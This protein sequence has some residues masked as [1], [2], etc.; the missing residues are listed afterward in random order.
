MKVFY[1]DL[2]ELELKNIRKPELKKLQSQIGYSLVDYVAKNFYGID[3][4]DLIIQNRKPKFQ[5]STMCFNISHS[6]EIVAVA[7]DT[8]PLGFDI[9]FIQPKDIKQ[10]ADRYNT[11]FQTIEDFYIFWTNLEA[12]I[13]IQSE[14]EQHYTDKIASNYMMTILSSNP[15]RFSRIPTVKIPT[16]RL[17]FQAV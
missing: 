15:E 17:Q 7:F 2:S 6:N 11:N 3:N 5:A 12:E 13:K 14:I 8:K 16:R 9:E 1:A 10:L 4:T